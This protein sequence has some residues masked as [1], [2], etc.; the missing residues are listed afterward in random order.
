MLYWKAH[1]IPPYQILNGIK[2]F[3]PR[4][5]VLVFNIRLNWVLPPLPLRMDTTASDNFFIEEP[6]NL[7]NNFFN[8]DKSIQIV[9]LL[10]QKQHHHKLAHQHHNHEPHITTGNK[11]AHHFQPF[12][13]SFMMKKPEFK[14]NS[15]EHI[16]QL[17]QQ[18]QHTLDYRDHKSI[19]CLSAFLDD[20]FIELVKTD[21]YVDVIGHLSAYIDSQCALL[22][23][24]ENTKCLLKPVVDQLERNRITK[25]TTKAT[26]NT[27][28]ANSEQPNGEQRKRVYHTVDII[29]F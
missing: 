13:I 2:E 25:Q 7:R 5:L 22:Q 16:T 9:E 28:R 23:E 12:S 27:R 24:L 10:A 21:E 3:R 26:T 14:L 20:H 17:L 4:L 19:D 15:A 8:R 29:E 6:Q 18:V 11:R 1:T